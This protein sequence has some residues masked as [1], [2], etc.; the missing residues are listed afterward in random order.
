[1]QRNEGLTSLPIYRMAIFSRRTIQRLI[2]ENASFLTAKQ[3]KSHVVNLNNGD[4][5]AEWEVVL[6]NVFSKLGRVEHEKN[7]NG[8]KPDIY[9]TSEDRSLDFLADIKT[10]SDEGT[11]L[12]NPEKQLDERLFKE[13]IEKNIK[14][15][16]SCAIGG[17]YEEARKTGS[18][19]RLKLPALARFDQEIF[20]ESWEEFTSRV[21]KEPS[22]EH[23][24]E[25][26][27][28]NVDLSISYRPSKQWTGLR[29][30]PSYKS[31][32]SRE[33]LIQNSVWNGLVSKS[34]QLEGAEYEGA[35][36]IILCDGGS[37]YLKRSRN[38][39][40]EF[41]RTHPRINFVLAFE[42]IQHFGFGS[43]NQVM[44]YF[45]SGKR[46][47]AT[48]DD[49]LSNLHKH[50]EEIFPYPVKSAINAVNTLESTKR[51]EGDSHFG[52]A[53]MSS[54]EIKLS[55][56]TVLDLLAGKIA[57]DEF[58]EVYKDFFRTEAAEGR[59]FEAARIE[60]DVTEQDDDWLVFSFGKPDPAVTPYTVPKPA[61]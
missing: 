35:L 6:L 27:T 54:N 49:F 32:T 21:Q 1:M 4:L 5:G 31:I 38:I 28:N 14:G 15:A 50:T 39:I 3:I 18:M 40:H 8:K 44:M 23:T 51:F 2:N 20:N 33:H 30:L 37:E 56:R 52:G 24:Y 19:V 45:E 11:E 47:G 17:N 36:G 13:I 61:M 26:K 58:P 22:I 42:A 9:F 34:E 10:V 29:R 55:S 25:I 16:W 7:F 43:F 57:Y 48:L 59:L 53:T 60:K 46:L 12:K 41:F